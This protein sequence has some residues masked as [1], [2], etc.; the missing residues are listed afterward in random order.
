MNQSTQQAERLDVNVGG[1]AEHLLVL[2][3]GDILVS[4]LGR[5]RIQRIDAMTREIS[6][7]A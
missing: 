1:W 2:P 7:V 6:T 5:G 3:D 4:N